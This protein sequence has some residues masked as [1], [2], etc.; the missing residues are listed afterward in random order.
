MAKIRLLLLSGG[1]EAG[2]NVLAMLAGRRADVTLVATASVAHEPALFDCDAVHLV[3][4]P[5]DH[6]A[7]ER[8]LVDLMERERIDLVIPCSD[9]DV[10]CCAGLRERHPA[11]A[12]RLLCGAFAVATILVDKWA[13]HEFCV[14]HG[15]P[16]AASIVEASAD[17]QATFIAA[18]GLPAIAKPRHSSSPTDT[19]LVH[20]PAQLATML[21]RDDYLAQEFLGDREAVRD[22]LRALDE[23]GVPLFHH[24]RGLTRSMH[25][26]IAPDGSVAALFNTRRV[27]Q[28]RRSNWIAIDD[29][30]AAIDVGTRSAHAF[31]AAG[32]RGPLD[33]ECLADTRGELRIHQI[34]GRFI[35]GSMDRWLLGQDEVGAA[36]A[37]FAGTPLAFDGKPAVTALEAFESRV[38]RAADPADV[39]ALTRDR[40][41]RRA[42]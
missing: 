32:W 11:L 8:V 19:M 24:V 40:V 30:P 39:A 29:D 9:E 37:A 1:T 22:Y 28:L 6:E 4:P 20:T 15:L 41:W 27:R 33:I 7:S 25:A 17:E 18:Y 5:S 14:E 3:P 38:G 26:I 36:V 2:Q 10:L 34:S 21:A 31:A 42:A 16:Y 23:E 35:G 13:S 12:P